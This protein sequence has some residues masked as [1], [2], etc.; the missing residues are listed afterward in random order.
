MVTA[1]AFSTR[2]RKRVSAGRTLRPSAL[3]EDLVRLL[4]VRGI[5]DQLLS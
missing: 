4:L 2:R 1:S 5:S 3:L